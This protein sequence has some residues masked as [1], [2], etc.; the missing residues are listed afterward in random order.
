MDTVLTV[1]NVL[2]PILYTLLCAHALGK[3]QESI[4][5]ELDYRFKIADRERIALRAEIDKLE[6]RIY[7][8]EQDEEETNEW[9]ANFLKEDEK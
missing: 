7:L 6:G 1:G 8:L 9:V 2:I 4:Q 3:K 5:S